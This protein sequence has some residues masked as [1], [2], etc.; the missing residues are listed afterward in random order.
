MRDEQMAIA[1]RQVM[2]ELRA[3]G[4]LVDRPTDVSAGKVSNEQELDQVRDE[5][6]GGGYKHVTKKYLGG[7]TQ[8]ELLAYAREHKDALGIRVGPKFKAM[9]KAEMVAKIMQAQ[10]RLKSAA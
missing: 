3:S 6:Q 9:T 2:E 1:R 4:Q 5:A 10:A 8:K 7:L